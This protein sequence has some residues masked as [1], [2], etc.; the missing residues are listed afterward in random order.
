MR[1]RDRDDESLEDTQEMS[2]TDLA[3]YEAAA[4]LNV[5]D[6]PATVGEITGMT[7]LPEETVRHC[8]DS[9]VGGGRLVPRGEAYQLGP[10]DWGLSY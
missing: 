1:E 8:L 2:G 10:H 3:V 4:A 6:R 5:A 7:G 9:L